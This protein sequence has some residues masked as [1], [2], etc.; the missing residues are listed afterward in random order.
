MTLKLGS[1]DRSRDRGAVAVEFALILLPMILIVFGIVE[2][3][4]AYNAQLSLQH[5][6][7]EGARYYALNHEDST[8]VEDT[9]AVTESAAVSIDLDEDRITVS[10]NPCDPGDPGS[11]N[12]EYD[13]TFITWQFGSDPQITLS[14][15]GVMRCGG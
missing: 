11:V 12:A 3:G 8:A 7:R 14:A 13:F 9:K 2:F 15:E 1:R 10:P 6:V 5:A 4:R